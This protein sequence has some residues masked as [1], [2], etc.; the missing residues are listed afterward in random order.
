MNSNI[1]QRSLE[2]DREA[3]LLTIVESLA[4]HM[5]TL[6]FFLQQTDLRDKTLDLCRAAIDFLKTTRCNEPAHYYPSSSVY[7]GDPCFCG[8]A[9]IPA[10]E[11]KKRPEP[12]L[13]Q[14]A[15]CRN[16]ESCAGAMARVFNRGRCMHCGGYFKVIRA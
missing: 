6:T 12:P 8:K 11:G 5:G 3:Q 13:L 14:C 7:E 9:R 4:T 10:G 1:F 2:G 15:D 16:T